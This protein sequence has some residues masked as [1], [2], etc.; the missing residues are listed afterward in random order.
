MVVPMTV[1][2]CW[3]R[4][5]TTRLACW[6]PAL[7]RASKDSGALCCVLSERDRDATRD[8]TASRLAVRPWPCP[9]IPSATTR[10]TNGV[11]G[12]DGGGDGLAPGPEQGLSWS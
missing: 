7:S 2:C 9:P 4:S 8:W 12:V 6:T 5:Y 11:G 10:R 3:L 1:C